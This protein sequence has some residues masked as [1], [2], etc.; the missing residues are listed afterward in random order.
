MHNLPVTNPKLTDQGTGW[1]RFRGI[2]L[3]FANPPDFALYHALQEGVAERRSDVLVREHGFRPLPPESYHV[4][5]WD[6]VNDGNLPRVVPEYRAAWQEFLDALPHP[7]YPPELFREILNSELLACPDWN[8]RLRCEQIENWSD[9]SLV[10]RLGPA[11]EAS[12]GSLQRLT[13]ARTALSEFH[14]RKFGV[15]PYPSYTPHI[16]LGYFANNR[17]AAQAAPA[18][19]RWNNGLLARAAGLTATFH[20]IRPSV[21]TDMASS[22]GD[23]P[24]D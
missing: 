15:G 13:R 16:T 12:A 20:R 6:G 8:L 3:L 2:S 10:A 22:V 21:F 17:L 18:V 5:A 14:Q 9:I 24:A 7:D 23:S 4:T 11:D 19:E 1:S